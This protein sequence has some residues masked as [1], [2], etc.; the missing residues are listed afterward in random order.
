M[1]EST[2][3]GFLK[4]ASAAALGLSA[5]PLGRAV[6]ADSKRKRVLYFT[7]SVG[8]EHVPVMCK[9]ASRASPIAS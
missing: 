1:N 6:G 9:D 4:S 2:R 8:F 7:A 3:R 5:F